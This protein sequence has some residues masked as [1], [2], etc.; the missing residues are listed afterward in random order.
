M[1]MAQAVLIVDDTEANVVLLEH[2]LA[3]SGYDLRSAGDAESALVL[4]AQCKP[5]LILMDV[6]LPGMSGLELTQH[7][8]SDPSTCDIRVIAISAHAM[9][10]DER[11]ALDAGC[12]RYVVKPIDTRTFA[13][14]VAEV[15]GQAERRDAACEA[16]AAQGRTLR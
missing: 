4:I 8:K 15:L 7:L 2:L 13:S 14:V 5:A 10:A 11:R 12:D 1:T 9:P 6:Q 3:L 16:P